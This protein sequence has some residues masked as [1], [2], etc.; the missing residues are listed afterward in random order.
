MMLREGGILQ[1]MMDDAD[2]EGYFSFPLDYY[3]YKILSLFSLQLLLVTNFL[4]IYQTRY[5]LGLFLVY[6]SYM[7]I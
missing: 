1:K 3:Y 4:K 6:I 2:S 5:I 7:S